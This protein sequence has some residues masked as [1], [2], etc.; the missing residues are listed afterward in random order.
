LVVTDLPAIKLQGRQ[1]GKKKK[2][3]EKKS[4]YLPF[5]DNFKLLLNEGSR[6]PEGKKEGKKKKKKKR[7]KT[8]KR[9]FFLRE[10]MWK[11]PR[12]FRN[13]CRKDTPVKGRKGKKKKSPEGLAMFSEVRRDG[14]H[15]GK[16]KTGEKRGGGGRSKAD[17]DFAQWKKTQLLGPTARD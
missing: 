12:A 17:I 13:S 4:E 3:A 9:F 8:R 5:P 14:G 1:S 10:K 7:K 11:S 6:N 16:E 2:G 15:G